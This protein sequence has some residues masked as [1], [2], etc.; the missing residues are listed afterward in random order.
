MFRPQDRKKCRELF[1]KYYA[2]RRFHDSLYRELILK[3]LLPGQRLLDAGYGRYLKFCKEFSRAAWV[4]GIDLEST[5]ETDNRSV[6]FGVRGDLGSLPFPSDDF[7]MV[8]SHSVVE[9]L[10]DTPKVLREFCR[11]LKPAGNVVIIKPNK[12]DYVSVI[13]AIA[14]YRVHRTLVSEIFQIPEDDIFPTLYKANTPSAMRNA[15]RSVGMIERELET[16]NHYPAYLM[17]SPV[18]FRLG[19]LYERLTSLKMFRAFRGSILCVFEKPGAPERMM[20]GRAND[21]KSLNGAP[22]GAS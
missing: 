9:H 10:E 7:D 2:G 4:A 11:V 12:H 18:L 5:L 16:I 15:F 19:V 17:F 21:S 20:A 6:P 3:H 14:P 8:I 13:A 22:V 1:E